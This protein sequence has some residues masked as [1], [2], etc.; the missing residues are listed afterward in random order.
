MSI[1]TAS[2]GSARATF[3]LAPSC[4]TS[5]GTRFARSLMWRPREAPSP[6]IWTGTGSNGLKSTGSGGVLN[7]KMQLWPR[8]EMEGTTTDAR[9]DEIRLQV[10]R[11]DWLTVLA[12]FTGDQ[13]DVLEI[14][15]HLTY[16]NRYGS[17]LA[18]LRLARDA[19]DRGEFDRAVMLARKA[20]NLMEESVRAA[21]G[22]ELTGALADRLDERHVKL[23]TSV[24]TRAKDMG[25]ISVHR[26]EAREYTRVEA[27]FSIRLATISLEVIA[28]LLAD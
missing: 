1:S 12:I 20:V 17:S 23:Y 26:A 3:S 15:Y 28:G 25:N 14:R 11:D 16:A 5:R 9:V 21:T 4:G 6:S 27:L 22:A 10:P 13:I 24:I 18:E 7:M 19:V 2:Y 8:I